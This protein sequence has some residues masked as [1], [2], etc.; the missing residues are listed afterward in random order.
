MSTIIMAKGGGSNGRRGKGNCRSQSLPD[1]VILA[2][3]TK[4]GIP[5]L[6]YQNWYTKIGIPKLVYQNRFTISGNDW[7]RQFPFPLLP[8]L[9]PPLAMIIVDVDSLVPLLFL[10]L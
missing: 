2:W 1:I 7:L 6:V 8:L 5:K 3:Y 10:S 9:P 4:I